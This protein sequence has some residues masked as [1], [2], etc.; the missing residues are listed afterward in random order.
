[1]ASQNRTQE[2]CC[3]E[4]RYHWKHYKQYHSKIRKIF[5]SSWS[6]VNSEIHF[7]KVRRLISYR[8]HAFRLQEL[9]FVLIHVTIMFYNPTSINKFRILNIHNT[10]QR[11]RIQF[12]TAVCN[13]QFCQKNIKQFRH[14][15]VYND[16][17]SN[18]FTSN[19]DSI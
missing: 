13:K 2:D 9:F 5:L 19:F 7:M 12:L 15:L 10:L 16:T 3:V 11:V 4:N 14:R 17:I 1:M 18:N 8:K 6:P